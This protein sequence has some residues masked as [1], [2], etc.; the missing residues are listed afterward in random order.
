MLTV[1]TCCD[2]ETS[3][4]TGMLA[5]VGTD[6]CGLVAE[7][8]GENQEDYGFTWYF[9]AGTKASVLAFTQE[10][11]MVHLV[12]ISN[13]AQKHFFLIVFHGSNFFLSNYYFN[14]LWLNLYLIFYKL[15]LTF[16]FFN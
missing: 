10:T 4:T 12:T 3:I 6:S 9:C 2:K 14:F 8:S 16:I 13:F 5:V 1:I 7:Q 15:L 11:S